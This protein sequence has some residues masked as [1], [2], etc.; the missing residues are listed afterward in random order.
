LV[1]LGDVIVE[2]E[3]LRS[4]PA[5]RA[6]TSIVRDLT[7]FLVMVCILAKGLRNHPHTMTISLTGF[8]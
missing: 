8:Y 3:D 1:T 7:F 4:S 2:G 6:F 5:R